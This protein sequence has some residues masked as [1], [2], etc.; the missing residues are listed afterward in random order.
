MCFKSM[1]ASVACGVSAVAAIRHWRRRCGDV[2]KRRFSQESGPENLRVIGERC[3]R[4]GGTL[5]VD[6]QVVL[7]L[8]LRCDDHS[9]PCQLLIDMNGGFSHFDAIINNKV[10]SVV[11]TSG[12]R[13]TWK[14]ALP[15]AHSN[16]S[17][18]TVW[19]V[20]RT[21]ARQSQL[22]PPLRWIPPAIITKPAVIYGVVVSKGYT[23]LPQE[24][25]LA[26]RRIEIIGDS[27]V[28]AFGNEGSASTISL[29]SIL[30]LQVSQQNISNSWAHAVC[31]MLHAEPS[32]VAWSSIA[33]HQNAVMSDPPERPNWSLAKNSAWSY[34]PHFLGAPPN[35]L[36][37]SAPRVPS[38]MSP[39]GHD[40]CTMI[41]VVVHACPMIIVHAC[42]L[43]V[44][45]NVL[46]CYMLVLRHSTC[47]YYDLSTCIYD[48]HRAC[49]Y[50]DPR[51]CM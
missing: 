21:E 1:V 43:I 38:N 16:C 32:V 11:R 36:Q 25:T 6:M 44:V 24:L 41:I 23:V 27:D 7:E 39:V 40:T 14:F 49:M 47:I 33:V 48:D 4:Q 2:S 35:A 30:G 51:T 37:T 5:K 28:A 13:E 34:E 22:M 29:C 10:Q 15:D 8:K 9:L 26:A 31:R 46:W 45:Q 42:I 20:K 17:E 18:T 50:Y 3:A 19:I 12:E